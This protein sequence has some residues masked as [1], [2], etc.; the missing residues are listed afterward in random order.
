[1]MDMTD[2]FDAPYGRHT[3]YLITLSNLKC[4]RVLIVS[5]AHHLLL[6]II[7]GRNPKFCM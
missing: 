2:N 3:K 4:P 5:G 7:K 1:M 6:Y